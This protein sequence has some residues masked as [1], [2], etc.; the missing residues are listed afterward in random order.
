MPTSDINL[1]VS[2]MNIL[3]SLM[4]EVR[5]AAADSTP[6]PFANSK[7][8]LECLFIFSLIWS[9]GATTDNNGRA[10]FSAFLRP[11]VAQQVDRSVDRSDFDLGPGLQ[12]LDP[13]QSPIYNKFCWNIS[14]DVSV[15]LHGH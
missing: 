9:V 11:L 3:W 2:L 7:A 15:L 13:G 12:I 4:D 1:P 5:A 10:K 8:V 14:T 6:L